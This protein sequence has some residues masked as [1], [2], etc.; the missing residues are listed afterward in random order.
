MNELCPVANPKNIE[1]NKEIACSEE[2]FL[3]VEELFLNY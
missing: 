3:N 1:L 2:I